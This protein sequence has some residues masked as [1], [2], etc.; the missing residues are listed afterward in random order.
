MRSSSARLDQLPRAERAAL[1][2][3]A[4]EGQVFHRSAVQALAPEDP[5]VPSRLLGLVRK[6]LVRPERTQLPDDDAFRFRHILIRDAAYDALPKATRAELHEL[7]ARWLDERGGEL[8]ELDEIVGHHLEQA[9]SLSGGA[10]RRRRACAR[11]GGTCERAARH[12]R[13]AALAR[14]DPHAAASLL[15]RA[16]ALLE[17]RDARRGRLLVGSPTRAS[18]ATTCTVARA[19][20]QQAVDLAQAL[21][22]EHLEALA[23]AQWLR[24]RGAHR[25]GS[26]LGAGG[27]GDGAARVD[28]RRVGDDDGL[29][30]SSSSAAR[31]LFFA[32]HTVRSRETFEASRTVARRAGNVR[33][34][35]RALRYIAGA[36]TRTGRRPSRKRSLSPAMP[37]PG[38]LDPT[39]RSLV[40]QKHAL[41]EA[42]RGDFDAVRVRSTGRQGARR[43]NTGFA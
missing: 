24:P 28:S 5:Q 8:V 22:D 32:G 7:F 12:G 2:R 37:L 42:M 17:R 15:T 30:T 25:S 40:V 13:Q 19:V 9:C 36:S 18:R 29:V 23:R 10:R 20:A 6:E 31:C 11:A 3:G 4:V 33:V 27:R 16:A 38:R 26:E 35:A 14:D 21:D 34:E 43:W 41:L 39:T 1:E